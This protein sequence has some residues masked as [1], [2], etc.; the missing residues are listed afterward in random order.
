MRRTVALAVAVAGIAATARA[1]E[2]AATAPGPDETAATL[3]VAPEEI[4]DGPD[5]LRG[6]RG[7]VAVAGH[8][9]TYGAPFHDVDDLDPGDRIELEV[10]TGRLHFFDPEDGSAIY[11][12]AQS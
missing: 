2:P 10:D 7:P 1:D 6:Q 9:T 8:R 4:D 12:E 3:A 11:G 5:R